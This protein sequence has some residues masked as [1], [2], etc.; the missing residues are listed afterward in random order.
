MI[1]G[2]ERP[3]PYGWCLVSA[4]LEPWEVEVWCRRFRVAD[5]VRAMWRLVMELMDATEGM[6]PWVTQYDH[7]LEISWKVK[8]PLQDVGVLVPVANGVE[9]VHLLLYRLPE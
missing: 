8:G 9:R 3:D 7:D 1:C 5:P 4:T 6:H 2:Q